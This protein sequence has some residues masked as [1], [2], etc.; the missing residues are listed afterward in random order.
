MGNVLDLK[1]VTL[2][3]SIECIAISGK[4]APYANSKSCLGIH[5]QELML[6]PK[7][8]KSSTPTPCTDMSSLASPTYPYVSFL[9]NVEPIMPLLVLSLSPINVSDA[10]HSRMTRGMFYIHP[11]TIPTQEPDQMTTSRRPQVPIVNAPMS[12]PFIHSLRSNWSN[13]ILFGLTDS[14]I[15]YRTYT[16]LIQLGPHFGVCF[17]SKTYVSQL[18]E[19]AEALPPVLASFMVRNAFQEISCAGTHFGVLVEQT[20]RDVKESCVGLR[21]DAEEEADLIIRVNMLCKGKVD[22]PALCGIEALHT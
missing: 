19:P 8:Q 16:L 11:P 4:A 2:V 17:T 14:A 6:L 21:G 13:V 20:Q 1:R 7:I 10:S 18:L 15:K 3:S 9:T 12:K 22:V 5:S